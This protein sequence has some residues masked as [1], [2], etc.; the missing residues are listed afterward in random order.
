[1]ASDDHP[2]TTPAAQPIQ[3]TPLPVPVEDTQLATTDDD[4][5][6]P[7]SR[8]YIEITATDRPLTPQAVEQ[9]MT[10]LY[11]A[12]DGAATTRLRD[13]LLG[14][15]TPPSVEWLLVADGHTDT[16]IRWLVGVTD[17]DLHDELA[18]ICRTALPNTYE[19]RTAAWHPTE[20]TSLTETANPTELYTDTVDHPTGTALAGVDIRG[21]ADRPCDWQTP[22]T[23]FAELTNDQAHNDETRRLP[24]TTLVETLLDAD[25]PVVYQVLCRP[26]RDIGPD[27]EEYEHALETGTAT[28]GGKFREALFPRSVDEE[29]AYEPPTRDQNRLD[30]LADRDTRRTFQVTA[31]AVVGPDASGRPPKRIAES[32]TNALGP[33]DGSHHELDATVHV[34]DPDEPGGPGTDRF[35]ALC[36]RAHAHVAYERATNRLCPSFTS[37]AIVATPAELPALCLLDGGALTPTGKRAVGVR[38][39]ERTGVALPEPSKLA[40]Y[41]PPGMALVQPLTSDRQPVDRPLVLPPDYQPRHQ[42]VVGDTGSG[43]SVLTIGAMLSNLDA[44]D[45]PDILFDYKGGGT[46]REYL[47][48]HYATQGDLDDVLYFD[49]T[50]VLPAFSFFD[51]GPL[52]EAGLPRE[53]AR[54][55]K[56]GHYEEILRGAM[57]AGQY[58]DATE[59]PRVI[60]NHLRALYDPVHGDTAFP[61]SK[62]YDALQRTQGSE[63]P[64][65]V[66]EATFESYFAGL[67]ER[68]RDVFTKIMG[69]A[70]SRV[71]TIA[72]DARLAPLFDRVTGGDGAH[73]KFEDIVDED[74]DVIFDFGGM[75]TRVKRTVTLVLLSNLWTALKAREE[76]TAS[77]A[78]NPQVNL[79]LEEA[80]DVADTELVDTLLAQ[81]RSFDLSVTLGVQFLEPLDSPDPANNTYREY[82]VRRIKDSNVPKKSVVNLGIGGNKLPNG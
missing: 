43:K 10:Q 73:F 9:A 82:L 1:M 12:L 59:S 3:P 11:R 20:F 55:R 36:D 56:T 79:Y 57:P 51:I 23:T 18:R 37:P 49:L 13:R 42:V 26:Y 60:R 8:P 81:G 2:T 78:D 65:S 30:D 64:P 48:A 41:R 34:D 4:L 45:G 77:D 25:A 29:R 63:S 5:T 72:T 14:D 44:T 75:E 19:L 62:L 46:A 58:D 22:L 38:H 52:L 66:S 17:P 35:E 24:L 76:R 7:D 15:A 54:S 33:V 39:S 28:L 16:S 21:H 6:E 68:D 27:V 31:R 74:T 47:Q 61:H 50:S 67:L 40:R 53:E 70:I 71:E 69:G 80:K 32:I